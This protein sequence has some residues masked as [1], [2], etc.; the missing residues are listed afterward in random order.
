MLVLVLAAGL[1]EEEAEDEDTIKSVR[2]RVSS[3]G[4]DRRRSCRGVLLEDGD[5]DEDDEKGAAAAAAAKLRW[6]A[7][8]LA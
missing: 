7:V 3:S 1:L 4:K 6:E 2:L 5:G 8:R